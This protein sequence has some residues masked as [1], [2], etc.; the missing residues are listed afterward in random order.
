MRIVEMKL[1]EA[2]ALRNYWEKLSSGFFS[3]YLIN[4]YQQATLRPPAALYNHGS[5]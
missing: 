3:A 1:P 4:I 2:K 5:S